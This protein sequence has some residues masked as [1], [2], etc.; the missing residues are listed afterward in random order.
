MAQQVADAYK[1]S[2]ALAFNSN[3]PGFNAQFAAYV[4]GILSG[5]ETP[6]DAAKKSQKAFEQGAVAA[7]LPGW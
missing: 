5:S 6:A 1:D 4:T 2:T 7:G 3:L